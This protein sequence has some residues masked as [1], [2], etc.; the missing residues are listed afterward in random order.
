MNPVLGIA[1]PVD[2]WWTPGFNGFVDLV[3]FFRMVEE[4]GVF[5]CWIGGIGNR[6]CNFGVPFLFQV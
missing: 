5:V 1:G 3:S 2:G 6:L 4:T